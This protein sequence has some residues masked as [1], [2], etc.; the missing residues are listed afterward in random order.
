MTLDELNSDV[1]EGNVLQ[2]CASVSTPM[3]ERDVI[4]EFTLT[5]YS[6]FA[7]KTNCVQYLIIIYI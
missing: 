6:Q 5:P 1:E 7:S 2:V 4:L 3:R